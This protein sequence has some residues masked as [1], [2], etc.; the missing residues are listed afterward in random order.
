[1]AR[2][3]TVFIY[4]IGRALIFPAPLVSLLQAMPA[5]VRQLAGR[6]PQERFDALA[7]RAR[8]PRR[9][10]SFLQCPA[11]G[12]VQQ[13]GSL[14]AG[15]QIEGMHIRPQ[16][17]VI[18]G[19]VAVHQMVEGM[20]WVFEIGQRPVTTTL[21]G[22]T[23]ALFKGAAIVRCIV[24]VHVEQRQAQVACDFLDA[25]LS[26]LAQ[27]PLGLQPVNLAAVPLV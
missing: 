21:T 6:P 22:L 9:E 24:Q 4:S 23:Q 10:Q 12:P 16:V 18:A 26:Q 3:Y 7:Q 11:R 19:I 17:C 13:A 27:P 15:E 8:C 5:Q 25:L 20:R 2:P 14:K 1:M